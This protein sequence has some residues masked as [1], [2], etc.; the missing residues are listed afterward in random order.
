MYDLSEIFAILPHR[1]PFLFVDGVVSFSAG[2]SI[3]CEKLL[4]ADEPFFAGHF[5]GR[6]MMPGVLISEALAQ[7][8][9]L[10]IG[11]T[12]KNH[13]TA[14]GDSDMNLVLAGVNMKFTTPANP[15]DT[16]RLTAQ[17]QK[18]YGN[19]FLFTVEVF[20][21]H[22]KIAGGTLTLA[23]TPSLPKKAVKEGGI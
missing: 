20:I 22:T 2:E 5:P 4:R 7:T 3:V 8:G 11:L 14:L 16:L 6:P 13:A 9:G 23:E 12:R 21:E 10:L 15:G 18:Q 1:S 19:L 17:L